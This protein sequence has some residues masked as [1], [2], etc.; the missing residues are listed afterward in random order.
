MA[1]ANWIDHV[2]ICTLL[3]S[4]KQKVGVPDDVT[5]HKIQPI[6]QQAL[7]TIKKNKA[8]LT[9][10]TELLEHEEA[11]LR[12]SFH[13]TVYSLAIA[14]KLNMPVKEL[15]QLALAALFT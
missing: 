2:N 6:L 10:L 3:A 13:V 14:S 12:H 7:I 5:T 11:L 15:Q 8:Y 9:V 1:S 4:L